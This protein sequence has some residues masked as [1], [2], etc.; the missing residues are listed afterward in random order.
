MRRFLESMVTVMS[1][2]P[3]CRGQ[4]LQDMVNFKAAKVGGVQLYNVS[5]FGG[6]STSAALPGGLTG[7]GANLLGPDFNYGASVATGWQHHGKRT[8]TAVMYAGTYLAMARYTDLNS[9]NQ[10]ASVSISRSLTTKW[11]LGL[12]GAASDT[13]LNQFMFQPTNLS[14]ISNLFASFDDLA[15]AFSVGRFS[16]AQVATMLTGSPILDTPTRNLL[17]GNRILSVSFQASVSYNYSPRLTFSFASFAAGAQ[18]VKGYQPG[19]LPSS[20]G[21]NGGV[22]MSYSLSPRTEIGSTLQVSRIYNALQRGNL[23]SAAGFWGRKMGRSWFLRLS[24][25]GAYNRIDTSNYGSF[26]V[27]GDAAIGVRMRNHSFVA[28][29]SRSAMDPFG[30][31][32]ADTITAGGS[33]S[34]RPAPLWTVF[35]GLAY[36]SWRRSVYSNLSGWRSSTGISKYLGSGMTLSAQYSYMAGTS[37]YLGTIGDRTIHGVRVSLSW[38][39]ISGR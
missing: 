15:A 22:S 21:I 32:A 23:Y 5:T 20:K 6:Y 38:S 16:N 27:T 31:A 25:G 19:A 18:R 3:L 9:Y 24:G 11:I 2:A 29:A 35:S 37:L 14:V 39:P 8:H 4:S 17:L 10:G 34:W 33:W 30:I 12:S 28:S 1:L 7:I 13:T 26:M 36:Q